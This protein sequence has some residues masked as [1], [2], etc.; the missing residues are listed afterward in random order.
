[1][2]RVVRRK[3]RTAMDYYSEG[4]LALVLR[5]IYRKIISI[6][7]DP[8]FSGWGMTTTT[9]TPWHKG[10]GDDVARDFLKAHADTVGKV[11]RGEFNLSQFQRSPSLERQLGELMWRHY[12]VFWSARYAATATKCPVKNLVECGVCDGL[13][14]HFAMNAL[15]MRQ[16]EFKSFLYDAWEA[17]RSEYLLASEKWCLGHY[18]Y[19]SIESTKRNLTA[20][21]KECNF[22]KGFIPDS[23]A[24]ASNRDE[25]D[26]LHI[27]LNSSLP[28]ARALEFFF[29]R[30]P[31]G[32]LVLLDDYAWQ[33]FYDTKLAVD[34]FFAGK[35]GGLLHLPTGQ[36]IFFKH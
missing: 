34:E 31:A 24:G 36:A 26:W 16:V 11:A 28:T 3:L 13:S 15:K 33:S 27:D 23:F 32:G 29:D 19:L 14:M 2:L 6:Q 21:D 30:I 25:V 20:F 1:M 9:F 12:I 35:K 8:V 17:M 4:G 18:A 7:P 10:G 22:I 5:V